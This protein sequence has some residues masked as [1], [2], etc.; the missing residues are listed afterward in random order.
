MVRAGWR[1]QRDTAD[2][3]R[4]AL[5]GAP[6]VGRR[7]MRL[8][9][10]TAEESAAGAA[11]IAGDG[12][13]RG[14]WVELR[15]K[16]EAFRAFEHADALLR[17]PI[18]G[19]SLADLVRRAARLPSPLSVWAAE[20]LGYHAAACS[21]DAAP[22]NLL[23]DRD[24]TLPSWALIPLH[25]GMGSALAARA[26]DAVPADRASVEA[27]IERFDALCAANAEPGYR[28]VAFEALGF[29]V[30]GMFEDMLPQVDQVVGNMRPDARR[31]VWHGV[32]R[33]VYFAPTSALPL[34]ATRR[35]ALQDMVIAPRRDSDRANA[36]AGFAWAATLVNLRDP[37]ALESFAVHAE[38]LEVEEPFARGI[39]DALD[40][41]C[42]CA[43]GD[44]ALAAFRAHEPRAPDRREAWTR[45]MAAAGPR[46][47]HEAGE[48]FQVPDPGVQHA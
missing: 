47:V 37:D 7:A 5:G 8:L 45:L 26:L 27:A 21:S 23:L 18:N 35:R 28:D 40:V 43:P 38:R 12:D 19:H 39:H 24:E 16:V 1:L 46:A 13:V 25:A 15:N 4:S 34:L 48:L 41:W 10:A 33:A 11:L 32:G 17:A 2:V 30:R 44:E 22:R 20:G 42:Q 9:L 29:V 36:I 6:D 31:L 3:L 14:V